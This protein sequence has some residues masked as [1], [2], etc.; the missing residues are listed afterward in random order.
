MYED[1]EGYN[2]FHIVRTSEIEKYDVQLSE[3]KS[4]QVQ[5]AKYQIFLLFNDKIGVIK[6]EEF[7]AIK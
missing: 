4:N 3:D 7:L 2:Q 1:E 5:R 6:G